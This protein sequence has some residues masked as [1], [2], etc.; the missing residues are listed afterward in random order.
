MFVGGFPLAGVNLRMTYLMRRF[1]GCQILWLF[2]V[3]AAAAPPAGG[4]AAASL[5]RRVTVVQHEAGP[6]GLHEEHAAHDAEHSSSEAG[7]GGH[8]AMGAQMSCA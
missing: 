5:A 7:H 1:V 8:A 2:S 3:T 4:E 6:A